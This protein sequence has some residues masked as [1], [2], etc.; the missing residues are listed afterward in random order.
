MATVFC[1]NCGSEMEETAKFCRRCGHPSSFLE[2]TTKS[3]DNPTGYDPPRFEAPTSYVN[4]APTM[5]SYMPPNA[6]TPQ[7]MHAYGQATNELEPPRKKHTALIVVC[8]I[9]AIILSVALLIGLGLYSLNRQVP[10]PRPVAST[11]D[12]PIPPVPPIPAI[13][14]PPPPPPAVG[15]QPGTSATSAALIYPGAEVAESHIEGDGDHMLRLRTMD[16]ASKVAEW[17]TEKLKPTDKVS[18]LGTTVLTTG[19]T[20]VVVTGLGGETTIVVTYKE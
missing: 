19:T 2:A 4:S 3:F 6:T 7:G 10:V 12:R 9:G 15:G 1:N 20:N 8:V 14:P 11:P 16:P 17:Y 18:I 13:P 5:P